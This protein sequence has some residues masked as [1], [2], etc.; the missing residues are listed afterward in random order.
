MFIELDDEIVNI[1][2]VSKIKKVYS[3]T[4]RVVFMSG[5]EEVKSK[6]FNNS[7]EADQFYKNL[8]NI[9][10]RKGSIQRLN[11]N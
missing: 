8:K 9:I 3:D 1:N 11:K 4:Y 10:A 6:V 2:L 7:T 5:Q